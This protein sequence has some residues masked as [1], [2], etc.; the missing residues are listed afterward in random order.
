LSG[1]ITKTLQPEKLRSKCQSKY[2]PT[3]S[4]WRSGREA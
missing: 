3:L 4:T 1:S 2:C